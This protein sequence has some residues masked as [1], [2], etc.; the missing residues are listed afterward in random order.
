MWRYTRDAPG[1]LCANSRSEYCGTFLLTNKIHHNHV[2]QGFMLRVLKD[3]IGQFGW[4]TNQEFHSI[5]WYDRFWYNIFPWLG[6]KT[7]LET[8]WCLVISKI[9]KSTH[10]LIFEGY[11]CFRIVGW[12]F[13]PS[14]YLHLSEW[15]RKG[16]RWSKAHYEV[17]GRCNRTY[18]LPKG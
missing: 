5:L 16:N 14:H 13:G 9:I 11:T 8:V 7:T 18:L 6:K 17:L 2:H 10:E 1:I 4:I 15:N 3:S 12:V